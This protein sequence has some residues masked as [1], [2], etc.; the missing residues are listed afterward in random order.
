MGYLFDNVDLSSAESTSSAAQTNAPVS[1]TDSGGQAT[2]DTSGPAS[3][4]VTSGSGSLT[5]WLIVAVVLAAAYFLFI[6]KR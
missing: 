3:P 2:T 5:I 6:K 1:F 4:A